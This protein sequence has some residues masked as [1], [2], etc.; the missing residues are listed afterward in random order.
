MEGGEVATATECGEEP[1]TTVQRRRVAPR[2]L[3]RG[4][5]DILEEE[6]SDG[7][8]DGVYSWK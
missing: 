4:E 1:M 7:C 2:Q 5:F 6:R 8:L 3:Q